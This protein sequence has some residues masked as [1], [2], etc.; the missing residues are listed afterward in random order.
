MIEGVTEIFPGER[1]RW[2]DSTNPRAH[3]IVL[4][5]GV[6]ENAEGE[7]WVWAWDVRRKTF[8]WNTESHFLEM[9]TERL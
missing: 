7:Y 3:T 4:V 8:A 9:I 6:R 2:G 5:L 1:F